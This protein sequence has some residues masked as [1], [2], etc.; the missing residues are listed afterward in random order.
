MCAGGYVCC[1]VITHTQSEELFCTGILLKM[2]DKE[3]GC[4]LILHS[5]A[6]C[7]LTNI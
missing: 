6:Y 1:L 5:G 2:E 7:R 3:G 4:K